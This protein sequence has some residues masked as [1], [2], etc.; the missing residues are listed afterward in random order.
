[1]LVASHLPRNGLA[2][3]LLSLRVFELEALAEKY[4]KGYWPDLFP[5][6]WLPCSKLLI[7]VRP[8]ETGL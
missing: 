6:N 4:L 8:N 3:D 5:G 2:A 7:T 1:M